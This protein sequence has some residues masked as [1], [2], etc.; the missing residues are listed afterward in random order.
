MCSLIFSFF[1]FIYTCIRRKPTYA[2]TVLT[3]QC[4]FGAQRLKRRQ[5]V[6]R[7]VKKQ[8]AKPLLQKEA[9]WKYQE[10]IKRDKQTKTTTYKQKLKKDN[11]RKSSEAGSK[12]VKQNATFNHYM[13]SKLGSWCVLCLYLKDSSVSGQSQRKTFI[14]FRVCHICRSKT[15]F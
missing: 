1:L 12:V 5:N 4:F 14:S 8:L 3:L 11:P 10:S 9:I 2:T 6:S 15:I 7:F 13:L